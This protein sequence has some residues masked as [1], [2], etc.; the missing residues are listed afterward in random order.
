MLF[1]IVV[2]LCLRVNG[3]KR[4]WWIDLPELISIRLGCHAFDF[5]SNDSSELI[6]RSVSTKVNWRIDLPKLTSLTAEGE[7]SD[8]FYYP[9]SVTLEGISYHSILTNRHA[10]SHYCHP[11]QES[12]FRTEENHQY[13]EFLFFPSLISRHHSCSARVSPI[14]CFFHASLIPTPNRRFHFT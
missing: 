10:L 4:E 1:V 8:T 14:H 5:K 12:G 2:V 7:D 11:W 3:L 6:M 9:R 13:Q